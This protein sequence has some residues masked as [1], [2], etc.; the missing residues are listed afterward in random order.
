MKR[1][2]SYATGLIV[3]V[4]LA[5]GGAQY[6]YGTAATAA[7]NTPSRTGIKS[8]YGVYT[9]KIIYAG[10]IV[11]LNSSGYAIPAT[12]TNAIVV[13]GRAAKTVDNRDNNTTGKSY[14]GNQTIDV[15]RGVFGWASST[16][17]DDTAIGSIAFVTDDK[18]VDSSSTYSIIAGVVVDYSD[19]LVWVDTFH[20]GRTAGSFTTLSASGASTLTGAAN[21]GSTLYVTGATALQALNATGAVNCASTLKVN[22]AT[23]ISNTLAVVGPL[24]TTSNATIGTT[25][26]LSKTL[27]T[28][29]ASQTLT[30]GNFTLTPT[31]SLLYFNSSGVATVSLAAAS[32][33]GQAFKFFVTGAENVVL[34]AGS[35]A[36]LPTGYTAWTNATGD[37]MEFV[38]TGAV[39][40]CVNTWNN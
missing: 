8:N 2:Q 9:N 29:P 6:S 22:G 34:S 39:W 25:L 11:A 37:G 21:L 1:M 12:D 33:E 4:L 17:T 10:T 26:T 31:N 5:L 7:V 3:L 27:V 19:S 32:V 24:T 30:G 16:F 23:A 36:T 35:T 38:S 40:S 28:T 14:S 18:T 13:V 20:I 15:E